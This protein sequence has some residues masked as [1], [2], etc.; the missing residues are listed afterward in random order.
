MSGNFDCKSYVVLGA[1]GGVG[2]SVVSKLAKQ[3][4]R[5]FAAA[6]SQEELDALADKFEV[7]TQ[8][9]DATNP[10]S[11]ASCFDSAVSTFGNFD[12]AVNCVGSI[13]LKPA[14]LT[15]PEEWNS[16]IS[17]NLTS[18]FLCV[19]NA[20]RLLA[21]SGG[22]LVLVSSAAARIGL[23]NHEAIA[24]AKAGIIG[25]T[26]SA[27]ASYARQGI[28]VNCVAPGLLDT[29]LTKSITSS[30]TQLERSRSMHALGRIGRADDIAS[31]IVWLLGPESSW[32]TGQ[33][34][35]V[36]GGLSKVIPPALVRQSTS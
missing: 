23:P 27:S 32:V 18:A 34:L 9:F 17:T 24:S 3:G 20:S 26:L 36:D 25:L 8:I 19:K 29:K 10:E 2:S 11:V 7:K 6:R 14:H 28:R 33:V 4:H 31:A 16:V 1:T 22:S 12:G 13:L 21:K 5:V 15:S 35:S 30:A